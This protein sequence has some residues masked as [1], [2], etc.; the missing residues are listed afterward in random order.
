MWFDKLF[1]PTAPVCTQNQQIE[2][3]TSDFREMVTSTNCHEAVFDVT[4][5]ETIDRLIH[6]E[7]IFGA[8]IVTILLTESGSNEL[9]KPNDINLH[10]GRNLRDEI[11]KNLWKN[12]NQPLTRPAKLSK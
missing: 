3:C 1:P 12:T 5:E 8:L 11:S 6:S 9:H 4:I 10:V 7:K 2:D